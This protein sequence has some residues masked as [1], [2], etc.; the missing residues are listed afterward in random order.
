MKRKITAVLFGLLL[1]VMLVSCGAG[2]AGDKGAFAGS[3][4]ES[5]SGAPEKNKDI[6]PDLIYDHSLAL[7]YAEE[8]SV[9]YYEG[10][11]VLLTIADDSRFLLIPPEGEEPSELSGDIVL[12][13]QPVEQIYLVASAVMDMFVSLDA[14]D[15]IGFAGLTPENWYI[16]EA[17]E[18]MEAGD[19]LYAGKYS[20]PDYEQILSR[21][22]GLA[23]ENTMIYHTPEVKEQLEKF[24]IPVLVDY[25]SYEPS[26]LGRMEW[27]KLYGILAGKE[28]RA[29]EA[30]TVQEKAYLDAG[31]AAAEIGEAAERGKAA[32]ETGDG[33]QEPG[34]RKTVAFFYITANGSVNVRRSSDYLPK[35]IEAAGGSY[36]F[37]DLDGEGASSSVTM[38]MEEFYAAAK[39]ADYII[40]NST[41]DGE[42]ESADALL[43]KNSLLRI[44]KRWRRAGCSARPKTCIS[45][46]CSLEPSP[47]ISAAC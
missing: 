39:D 2:G 6:S 12:L 47:R 4:D 3:A 18:A 25:S 20:A 32:A 40:Y 19:I 46:P 29:L 17:R 31:E 35:M 30:F 16:E 22:C 9:D 10:G 45:P 36:I 37:R 28:D 27:I 11:Y 42:L 24:G 34:E 43:A 5:E 14:L 38:Q 13:H 7:S 8:F 21:G 33:K 15:S 41:V 1:T 23:V 26:P 44:L